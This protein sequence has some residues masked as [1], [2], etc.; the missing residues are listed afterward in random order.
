MEVMEN[1]R[2]SMQQV[3]L[4]GSFKPIPVQTF[5]VFGFLTFHD[6]EE[7]FYY[8]A[9]YD[10]ACNRK[11]VPEYNGKYKCNQCNKVY[12]D[13]R[14]TYQIAAKLQDSSLTEF[15]INFYKD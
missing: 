12:D 13:C 14:P 15:F 11:V 5:I 4:H 1:I 3:K 2:Q 7:K 9:C 8:D 6:V 10:Q